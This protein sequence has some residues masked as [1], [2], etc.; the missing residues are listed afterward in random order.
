MAIEN[1]GLAPSIFDTA[2][3]LEVIVFLKN[4]PKGVLRVTQSGE[5]N[6]IGS[7][8]NGGT[9]SAT[10]IDG[11]RV[12][13]VATATHGV[14]ITVK[15]TSLLFDECLK[16]FNQQQQFPSLTDQNGS[17]WLYSA[18]IS[19]VQH[20][21]GVAFLNSTNGWALNA[22]RKI[23][24]VTLSFDSTNLSSASYGVFKTAFDVVQG[25]LSQTNSELMQK[26]VDLKL[27]RNY[28]DVAM[29]QEQITRQYANLNATIGQTVSK[30]AQNSYDIAKAQGLKDE[31]ITKEVVKDLPIGKLSNS[32][33]IQEAMVQQ[34]KKENKIK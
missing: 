2:K 7:S 30:V 1:V 27:A 10:T 25:L 19:K 20:F 12:L 14:Q 11:Y 3:D 8:V 16:V 22:D 29:Q 33:E 26:Q 24:E 32:P 6:W 18:S 15:R 28:S 4:F 17:I 31:Q 21:T 23:Q 13:T 34:A 5:N 9:T